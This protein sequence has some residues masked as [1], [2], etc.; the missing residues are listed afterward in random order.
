MAAKPGGQPGSHNARKTR[1]WE[2]ALKRILARRNEMDMEKGLDQL[3][4]KV[5]RM[6]MAGDQWALKEIGDRIDGKAK[7]II[8]G[9]EEAPIRM[10][11]RIKLVKP[12]SK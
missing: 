2:A 4:H 1:H 11:G 3:A 7:Q 8:G 5:V 6:A 12:D 9:D 10:E